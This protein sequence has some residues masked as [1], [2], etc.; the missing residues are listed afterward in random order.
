MEF[1]YRII[2]AA[3][4][5]AFKNYILPDIMEV[6]AASGGGIIM[7]GAVADG[8]YTCGAAAGVTVDGRAVLYSLY[9]DEKVRH[10]GV[11]TALLGEF[12]KR[13]EGSSGVYVTWTLP[14]KEFEEAAAF[15]KANGFDD[16]YIDRPVYRLESSLMINVPVLGRAFSPNFRADANIVPVR[17]FT[18][19]EMQELLQDTDIDNC[20]KLDSFGPEQINTDTCLGYR[21]GGHIQAYFLSVRTGEHDYAVLAGVSL[22]GANPAAFLLLAASALHNAYLE[23]GGDIYIWLEAINERSDR[24]AHSLSSNTCA[25]WKRGRSMLK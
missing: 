10:M 14:E 7:V 8:K 4:R 21:Y 6:S 15:L 23:S 25:L 9:V 11:G 20:L 2:E 1:S 24:L 18:E 16:P 19:D 12:L 13:A 3:D 5:E 17:D 22:K